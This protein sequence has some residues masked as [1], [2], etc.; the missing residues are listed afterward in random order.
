MAP[1]SG[2]ESP[3]ERFF[4][5]QRRM[6]DNHLHEHLCVSPSLT[7]SKRPRFLILGDQ[8]PCSFPVICNAGMS[9]NH[10]LA[11]QHFCQ[12]ILAA[13]HTRNL[14]LDKCLRDWFL[15]ACSHGVPVSDCWNV[16]C[17]FGIPNLS[18]KEWFNEDHRQAEPVPGKVSQH[19][20]SGQLQA[21]LPSFVKGD[22][23]DEGSRSL[24]VS[25]NENNRVSND[26]LQGALL[27]F[28]M[29]PVFE[30]AHQQPSQVDTLT[31]MQPVKQVDSAQHVDSESAF[32]QD[33]RP[34]AEQDEQKQVGPHA[35][36]PAVQESSNP[37]GTT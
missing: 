29:A 15:W 9:Q 3:Y 10:R 23:T 25:S 7:P 17:T 22:T 2:G 30:Q 24:V 8:G 27:N 5:K 14:Q 21:G 16:G 11:V 6:M 31:W 1:S 4:S 13:R 28:G 12:A 34:P 36:L 35:L 18:E 19:D 26:S 33:L 20:N 37:S 32:C